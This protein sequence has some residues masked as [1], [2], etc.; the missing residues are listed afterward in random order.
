MSGKIWQFSYNEYYGKDVKNLYTRLR[1]LTKDEAYLYFSLDPDCELIEPGFLLS[2]SLFR[3]NLLNGEITETLKTVYD[4]ESND[5]NYYSISISPTGRRLAY[6]YPQKTPLT[7]NMLDLQTSEIRSYSLE[8]KY[9]T[10][11]SFTWSEDGTKLAF[12]LESE[13]DFDRFISM[14]F[15]DLLR[16][17]SMVTFIN[18]KEYLWISSKL[19]ILDNEIKITPSGGDPLFYDIETG[20]LSSINQ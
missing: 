9:I 7:L 5:G 6:I 12:M 3:M 16:D 1:H 11:G 15:V 20:I 18:D 4:F 19:E 2:I 17:N 13:K 10:G 8:E 14:V